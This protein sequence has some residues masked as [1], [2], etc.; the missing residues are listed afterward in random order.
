MPVKFQN[1]KKRAL[2]LSTFL[3]I[4]WG[5]IAGK[6]F[7]IQVLKADQYKSLCKRQ[8]DYRKTI[9]PIRG[10]IFDRNQKALTVDIVQYTVAVHPYLIK[11]KEEFAEELSVLLRPNRTKYLKI[12]NSDRTYAVLERNISHNEIQAFLDKYQYHNAFAIERKIQRKYPFGEIAGQL[13]GF[14]DIDNHGI[15]GLEKELDPYLCGTPGW[16]IAQ[17]DGWGRL[18]NRPDLPYQK[19]VDGNDIVL[20]ID[21]EY[22]TILYEELLNAFTKHNADKAMGIIINPMNGKILSMASIPGFDPNHPSDYSIASQINHVV[23]D[24]YEPGSTFK[25]VT[26]TAAFDKNRIQPGDSINCENGK[27]SIGKNIIHDHKKYSTLSFAEVIEKS[28]NIGTIKVAQKIGKDEVFS[29]ARRFGFGAKTDIQFPGEQEGILHPLRNWSDLTLAQVAIGHGVCVTALQLAYAYAAIAN[30]GY[31][32]KPQ[33]VQSIS[34]KDGIN[35]YK[36]KPQYIRKV[37]STETM[38]MMRKLLRVTV[39]SGT[40]IRADINGMAIAGK[41]GTAQKVTETGYSQ[42]D[43]IATFVGFFPA[44]NPKLL[45]VIIVDNPKGAEHT[46]GNVSAPVL[47]NVFSR[48]VNLSDDLFLPEEQLD[49]P[50]IK[51]VEHNPQKQK[52]QIQTALAVQNKARV[53]LSSYQ[54]SRRMPDLQGKSLRQAIA[55]LQTMGI[56]PEIKGAGIVIS[57]YPP[58][59]TVMTADQRCRI[60]L[61]PKGAHFE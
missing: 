52:T 33:L 22:Q 60:E 20:T 23:T 43:Y 46:G 28:S 37:A 15:I 54:Y 25:I 45:C 48:I 44:D 38:Q 51:F 29:Y 8:A 9:A 3:V 41:T 57:Q 55:I 50:N 35:L 1:I 31:L 56:D 34:T 59:N 47:R 4:I 14:T 13:I 39:Q 24:I 16:Q 53:Q 18:T 26:A 2:L 10:A 49:A 6:L 36:S 58:K 19:T 32:L 40:G 27:M 7:I 21:N 12:L 42:T 5:L 17:K 11:E 30:G 61:R